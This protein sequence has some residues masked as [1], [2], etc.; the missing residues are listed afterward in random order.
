MRTAWVVAAT[1]VLASPTSAQTPSA[2]PVQAARVL[3]TDGSVTL[4]HELEVKAA[5]SQV[6]EAISTREGWTRWA[7]PVA[8]WDPEDPDVLET[9]YDAQAAYG[10]PQN[11]RQRFL[12]RVPNRLLAFQTIKAPAGF[13]DA[14]TFA[15]I[16]TVFELTPL[17]EDRARINLTGTGYPG[18]EAGRR[19]LDFFDK[20]NAMT[21]EALRAALESSTASED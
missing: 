9:S 4:V 19:L 10:A 8:W 2:T 21:L 12:V 5:T 3:E 15:G 18:D 17:G 14:Q 6:W 13:A 20:G 16:R 1:L 11:I 7:V